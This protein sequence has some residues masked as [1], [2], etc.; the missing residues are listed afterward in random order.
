MMSKQKENK[1]TNFALRVIVNTV[2]H[3]FEYA[4][5]LIQIGYEP[6]APRPA[7]TIFGKPALKLPNIF[8]YEKNNL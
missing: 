7:K 8:E 1:W 4:K 5:I 3:P 2:S 6:I